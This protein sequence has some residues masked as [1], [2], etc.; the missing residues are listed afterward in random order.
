[1]NLQSVTKQLESQKDTLQSFGLTRIGIFG[2][3]SRKDALPSSD[4][5][6]LLDFDPAK[7]TYKNFLKSTT[8]LESLFHQPVDVVTAQSLS[9]YIQ[10]HIL[11]D[12]SYVQISN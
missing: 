8:L 11:K 12:I 5:D 1:M 7:K 2:S 3:V 6:L 9:P 10:P 4:I